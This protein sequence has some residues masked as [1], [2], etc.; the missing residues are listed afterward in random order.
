MWMTL[1]IT[2]CVA[3]LPSKAVPPFPAAGIRSSALLVETVDVD[4]E[5]RPI[6]YHETRYAAERVQLVL[7]RSM[8]AR[9]HDFS[10][11]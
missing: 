10:N 4:S 11:R 5:A 6:V 9:V 1:R 2:R 3:H 8:S 7:E